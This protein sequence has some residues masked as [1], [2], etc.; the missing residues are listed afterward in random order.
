MTVVLV[1]L[2]KILATST[3]TGPFVLGGAVPSF[4]GQET[5]IDGNSYRYSTQ[6]GSQYEV[7]TGVYT[8]I[9][10]LLTR[11]VL[12][13]SNGNAAIN[14]PSNAEI[15]FTA[16]A[17]DYGAGA[18]ALQAANNL[19]DV[20][21]ASL[22]RENLALVPGTNIQAWSTSLDTIAASVTSYSL[23]LLALGGPD[24][25]RAA[26][27]VGSGT[28]DLL[29]SQNLN[30]VASKST[31]RT[32]L[33]VAIGSD[34]QAWSA[35]LDEYA[36]VNPTAA[37]LAL[38]DDADAA[39]QRVT[40]AV[41]TRLVEL[42]LTG[43]ALTASE[44]LGAFTPPVGETW[45]F[46]ANLTTSYGLKLNGGTNPASTFTLDVVKNGSTVATISI[47]TSG[48]VTFTTAGGV[49]FSLTGGADTCKVVGN[50]TPSVAVGYV[51]ALAATWA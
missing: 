49:A 14:L 8:A 20:N 50:V 26:L 3:G 35:N 40:L 12:I 37:G 2:V 36:A 22:S 31:S 19:S 5:L 47:S 51:I 24:V 11:D 41:N 9:G 34:V 25:W 38:L 6:P 30:D 27:G 4:R 46:P 7:G 23:D 48:V 1:D 16:I 39:A 33:G 28:G 15:A 17:A 18:N 45:T 21:S 13:S 42:S 43:T 32:N 29:A 10:G 44:I